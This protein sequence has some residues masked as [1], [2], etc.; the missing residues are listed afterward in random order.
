MKVR[1][2]MILAMVVHV[3]FS[4][5]AA[6]SGR[7]IGT[8]RDEEGKPLSGATVYLGKYLRKKDVSITTKCN[9]AGEYEFAEANATTWDYLAVSVEP[10]GKRF[11]YLYARQRFVVKAGET[12]RADVTYKPA[13]PPSPPVVEVEAPPQ[14]AGP[15]GR[16]RGRFVDVSVFNPFP[17]RWDLQRI[18]YRVRFDGGA[19]PNSILVYDVTKKSLIPHQFTDPVF[20]SDGTTLAEA[21][22][23]F[24]AG[25]E[26]KS[27][28][29]WRIYYGTGNFAPVS[30]N[31]QSPCRKRR[32]LSL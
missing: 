5:F 28:P 21:R 9:R 20:A 23:H 8:V 32:T 7:V 22:V 11:P 14:M 2:L 26:P 24:L 31:N 25:V 19:V 13:Q 29:F 12:T 1:V 27:R 17:Y 18:G 4:A 10:D 16:M 3:G 15:D 6:E 30:T